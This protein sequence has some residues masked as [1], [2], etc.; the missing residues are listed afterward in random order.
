MRPIARN[1]KPITPNTDTIFQWMMRPIARF[2][3]TATANTTTTAIAANNTEPAQL[4]FLST[5]AFD[6]DAGL[7]FDLEF[8]FAFVL[9]RAPLPLA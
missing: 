6:L 9:A 2:A 5:C 1:T 7:D 3:T 8:L 4:R